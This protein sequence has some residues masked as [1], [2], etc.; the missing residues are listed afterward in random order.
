MLGRLEIRR[1]D[2]TWWRRPRAWDGRPPALPLR[3]RVRAARAP[4]GEA[5]TANGVA[6]REAPANSALAGAPESGPAALPSPDSSAAAPTAA[7]PLRPWVAPLSQVKKRC[8]IDVASAD[9]ATDRRA[10]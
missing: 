10:E 8:G 9:Q 1:S 3:S 7:L 5:A 6:D 2:G 4:A